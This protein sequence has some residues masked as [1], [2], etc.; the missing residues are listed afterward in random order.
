MDV[1][2]ERDG[3]DCVGFSVPPSSLLLYVI[4][5]PLLN[6]LAFIFFETTLYIDYFTWFEAIHHRIGRGLTPSLETHYYTTYWTVSSFELGA[7]RDREVSMGRTD[8]K[9]QELFLFIMFSFLLSHVV[10]TMRELQEYS[11]SFLLFHFTR[12]M[13]SPRPFPYDH[14]RYF[15][16]SLL[17]KER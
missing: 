7:G 3:R 1:G 17:N 16:M 15:S 9:E 14:Y 5:I 10:H 12:S 4:V 11:S 13:I 2:R 6:H 8:K